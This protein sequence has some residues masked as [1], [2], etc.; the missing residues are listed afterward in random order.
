MWKR[1]VFGFLAFSSLFQVNYSS[2][3]LCLFTDCVQSNLV[4]FMAV[5]NTL[6]DRGHNVTIVT[7]IPIPSQVYPKHKFYHILLDLQADKIRKL[8]YLH[9]TMYNESTPQ[10]RVFLDFKESGDTITKMQTDVIKQKRFQEFFHDEGNSFDL[11]IMGYYY[12]DFMVGIGARYGCPIAVVSLWAPFSTLTRW[13]GNPPTTSYVQVP[14]TGSSQF[15]N[16]MERFQNFIVDA[17]IEPVVHS[18]S[19]YVMENIYRNLFPDDSYPSYSDMIS[20]ISL[21]L[22]N[23]HFSE[24]PIRPLVPALVEIGGIQVEDQSEFLPKVIKDFVDASVNGTIFFRVGSITRG[25]GLTPD[26]LKILLN[27]LSKLDQTVVWEWERSE[28]HP[29]EFSNILFYPSITPNT[30]L[31]HRN[32]KLYITD[33]RPLAIQEAIHHGVPMFGL[34]LFCEEPYTVAQMTNGGFGISL[35]VNNLTEE[36][37][38]E[39][40]RKILKSPQ[41]AQTVKQYSN[42]YKDRPNTARETAAFWLEYVIRYRG[43]LHMQSPLVHMNFI[44]RWN[45]DV[46]VAF[47]IFVWIFVKLAYIIGFVVRTFVDLKTQRL[48]FVNKSKKL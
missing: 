24:L 42:L 39:S 7:S 3:V 1:Y 46:M 44:Q 13:I 35:D 33:G 41:Y 12:N 40:L 48:K 29:Q 45:I 36:G 20:N 17:I 8:K 26:Q 34:P 15:M 31:P 9:I 2:N 25:T 28:E 22:Y 30:I 23:R 43:A 10:M 27:V 5:A 6:I 47:V 21:V 11:M 4:V 19:E 38:N 18:Y 16:F 14:F 37:F 32:V